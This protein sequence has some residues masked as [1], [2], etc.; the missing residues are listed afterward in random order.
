MARLRTHAHRKLRRA[1]ERIEKKMAKRV[2]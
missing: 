2:K 1:L